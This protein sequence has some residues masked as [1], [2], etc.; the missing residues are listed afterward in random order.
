MQDSDR[1]LDEFLDFIKIEKGLSLNTI[2]SYQRDLLKYVQYLAKS[3]KNDFITVEK[4][5]ARRRI[6]SYL[7]HLH[8]EKLSSKSI[9]RNL[10]TI[11][12]FYKFLLTQGYIPYNP[13]FDIESPKVWRTLP[14]VLTT[15]EIDLLL[16]KVD[17]K[18]P[19]GLRD[20][21]ILELLY[22][23]GLRISE[24]TALKTSDI[25]FQSGYLK[26]YGKGSKERIVPFGESAGFAMENY[27]KKARCNWDP[28]NQIPYFFL[29]RLRKKLTRQTVWLMIKLYAMKAGMSKNIYPHILRHS[30]ATHL[31]ERGADL[32]AVQM[33]LGHSDI[34]TTQIYTHVNKEHLREVYKKYHP[35]S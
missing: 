9:A 31:L 30:F 22:A 19:L 18:T 16:G 27:L 25:Y 28:Q 6:L 35:R 11:R 26:A 14:K 12:V 23:S 2:E 8:K 13:T 34:S 20:R 32:R 7:I 1:Y 10:V 5:E 15:A 4:S 29:S 33:M 21:A 24:L 3:A 17:L